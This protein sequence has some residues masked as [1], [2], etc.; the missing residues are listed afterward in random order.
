MGA[1]GQRLLGVT[2]LPGLLLLMLVM[3]SPKAH[4]SSTTVLTTAVYCYTYLSY[5]RDEAFRLTNA[6]GASWD[7]D[8]WQ[9]TDREHYSTGGHP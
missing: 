3:G 6:I 2:E 1:T 7:L 4:S 8:R 9:I 5:E